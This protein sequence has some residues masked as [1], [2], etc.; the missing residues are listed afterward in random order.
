[1]SR[2]LSSRSQVE[3][4]TTRR[5]AIFYLLITT[6][7]VLPRVRIFHNL[8]RR[9]RSLPLPKAMFR[10]VSL[11]R[12][13]CSASHNLTEL[14]CSNSKHPKTG[15]D[16]SSIMLFKHTNEDRSPQSNDSKF[17]PVRPLVFQINCRFPSSEWKTMQFGV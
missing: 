6:V 13:G 16:T 14:I 7:T 2:S 10:N 12:Q 3:L 15:L 9:K 5:P 4:A 8:Q 11:W 17:L 1:V